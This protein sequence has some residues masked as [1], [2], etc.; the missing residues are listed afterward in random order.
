MAEQ[1]RFFNFRYG[2][3]GRGRGEEGGKREGGGKEGELIA[4]VRSG[5]AVT[6]SV[7]RARLMAGLVAL[8]PEGVARCGKKCVSIVV[9]EGEGEGEE[10]EGGGV[11]LRFADGTEARHDAVIGCDGIKS[12]VRRTLLGEDHPASKAVFTGK[13]CYRGLA[14]AEKAIDILGA[15]S[16]MESQMCE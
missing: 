4:D 3:K 12:I 1:G 5:G 14:P 9:E 8:L 13:C 10:G 7:H 2:M 11:L 6:S 16:A 15:E